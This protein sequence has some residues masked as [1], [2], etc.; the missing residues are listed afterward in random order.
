VYDDSA[1]EGMCAYVIDTGI[2]TVHPVS[3][4]PPMFSASPEEIQ[5]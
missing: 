5:G 3:V 4:P 1:G 2:C